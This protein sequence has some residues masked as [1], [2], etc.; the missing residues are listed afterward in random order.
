MPSFPQNTTFKPGEREAL[1]ASLRP[2]IGGE[3]TPLQ[4]AW[5]P[6]QR[7]SKLIKEHT[8]PV[9]YPDGLEGFC[10]YER[11]AP[12]FHRFRFLDANRQV[13]ATVW[14]SDR[15]PSA[16]EAIEKKAVES[17]PAAF[18]EIVERER[19][20]YFARASEY[21]GRSKRP[22]RFQ[23]SPERAKEIGGKYALC[24]PMGEKG[25]KLLPVTE[26][27]ETL[28]AANAAWRDKGDTRLVVAC[29]NRLDRCW[30]KPKRN[31]LYREFPD[32]A[33]SSGAAS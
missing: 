22:E 3:S 19:K 21:P 29:G 28:E 11:Q 31:T 32:M 10:R 4:E 1:E 12:T 13:I 16:V 8:C 20:E 2:S 30:E 15:L 25:E 6:A 18:T 9:T 26:T 24:V 7:G 5:R 23:M 33:P 17:I 27:F 14:H